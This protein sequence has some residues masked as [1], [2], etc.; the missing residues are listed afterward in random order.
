MVSYRLALEHPANC[1]GRTD[2]NTLFHDIRY[3]LRIIVG[4]PTLTAAVTITLCLGIGLNTTIFT[5]VYDT[6]INPLPFKNSQLL[7][8]IWKSD[9]LF[10]LERGEVSLP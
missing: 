6:L 2:V 8:M 3:G 7:V 5:V 9:P 4:N 10:G 1:L